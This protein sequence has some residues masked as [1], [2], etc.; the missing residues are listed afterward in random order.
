MS[1][2]KCINLPM[3]IK[4][5]IQTQQCW[6]S[7]F[8]ALLQSPEISHSQQ[9]YTVVSAVADVKMFLWF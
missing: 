5:L 2:L 6:L 8:T 4:F 1:R 3:M 9:Q 7:Y